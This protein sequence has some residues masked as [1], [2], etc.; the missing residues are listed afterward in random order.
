[1]TVLQFS[2]PCLLLRAFDSSWIL[3]WNV[4][5]LSCCPYSNKLEGHKTRKKM[6]IDRHLKNFTDLLFFQTFGYSK[7]LLENVFVVS[8][9]CSATL[10]FLRNNKLE[11]YKSSKDRFVWKFSLACWEVFSNYNSFSKHLIVLEFFCETFLSL[12][13]PVV[14]VLFTTNRKD[15]KL[16]K[17]R[18]ISRYLWNLNDL[19]FFQTFVCSRILTGNVS[20][21]TLF[22]RQQ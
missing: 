21:V 22:R 12:L 13:C 19:L 18:S 11:G 16:G 17:K 7:I 14:L 9:F 1:M 3:L 20:V 6:S 5:V 4:L 8:L 2:C 15:I 10:L